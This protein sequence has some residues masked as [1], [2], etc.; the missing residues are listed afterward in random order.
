MNTDKKM[1]IALLSLFEAMA[2][3]GAK[4]T[5]QPYG[6]LEGPP[7]SPGPSAP[8]G[9]PSELVLRLDAL[10]EQNAQLQAQLVAQQQAMQQQQQAMQQ[11]QQAL[12]ELL[13]LRHTSPEPAKQEAPEGTSTLRGK[14]GVVS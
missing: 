4:Y 8:Q 2:Q 6:E 7:T 13:S 10:Q 3:V 11:Q 12:M 1:E 9:G 14:L 5:P